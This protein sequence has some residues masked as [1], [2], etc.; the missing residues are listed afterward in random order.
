[1]I[2]FS[3]KKKRCPAGRG[4]QPVLSLRSRQRFRAETLRTGI[5]TIGSNFPVRQSMFFDAGRGLQPNAIKLR[6]NPIGLNL[7]SD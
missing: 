6:A 1:M 4:L 2:D 3:T 7:F 5:S